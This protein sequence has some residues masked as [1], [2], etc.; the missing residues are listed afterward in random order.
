M[1]I[2]VVLNT[3]E[4]T[5]LG[6]PAS[7]DLQVDIG[8]E[9]KRGSYIYSG[10]LDPNTTST[11]FIN[12]PPQ[13][14][15]LYYRTENNTIY[16]YIA[17]PGGNQW[18]VIA[19]FNL[20]VT[21]TEELYD[22][23]LSFFQ[24]SSA[25]FISSGEVYDTFLK[26]V[27]AAE[28]Y[29]TKEELTDLSLDSLIASEIISTASA[30]AYSSAS[31]YTDSE[32][33][34]AVNSANSYTDEQISIVS[35]SVSAV[36]ASANAYTDSLV[37]QNWEEDESGN[38][39][40]VIDGAFDIGSPDYRVKD[41]YLSSSS[42]YIEDP[43]DPSKNIPI[44]IDENGNLKIG[45]Q[46]L[47]TESSASVFVSNAINDLVGTTPENLNTLEKLAGAINNDADFLASFYNKTESD[48][49]FLSKASAS[50]QYLS[51][52]GGV[53]SGDLVVSGSVTY[54][55]QG[56]SLIDDNQIILNSSA[57]GT[58][59]LDATIQVNRGSQPNSV[60]KWNESVDKWQFTNNGTQYYDFITEVPTAVNQK[61]TNFYDIARDYGAVPN[62][63]DSRVKIQN[64]LNAARD[65]GGGIVYIPNGLWNLSGGL[66]IYS[67]THLMLSPKAYMRKLFSGGSMLWNGDNGAN[68][69]GYDGQTN[70]TVTGGTWDA[71]GT[72][73]PT[74]PAN[75]F[76]FAH[77][78]NLIFRDITFLNVGG[79]HAIEINST[80]NGIVDNC[81]FLGYIDTGDRGFSEAV[82]IDGAFRATLFGE[83]G[84]Y[85]KTTCQ[86]IKITNCYFGASG[87]GGTTAWPTAIGSH[88]AD[89]Q[90]SAVLT[91]RWHSHIKVLN[92]TFEGLTEFAVRSDAVWREAT[93]ADN[94]FTN[95][96]GGVGL[97]FRTRNLNLSWH[98]SFNFSIE[99][100]IFQSGLD[101]G[102]DVIFIRNV[103]GV[104]ISNN[105]FRPS[106]GTSVSYGRHGIYTSSG[107]EILITDNRF[108]WVNRHG[109]FI[110]NGT[111]TMISN[112]LIK[113]V[114]SE[115]NN[116]YSYI[117]VDG[118]TNTSM[119]ANRGYK[120]GAGST[121]LYGLRITSSTGTRGFGNFFGAN[122]TTSVSGTIEASTA[123]G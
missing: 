39:L 84:S 10:F 96:S 13:L 95:C 103:D 82:Q 12:N 78:Q 115:T 88:S 33:I 55:N 69:S 36:S 20:F 105:H 72:A 113:N 23:I 31:S 101:L 4:I 102:R 90:D 26:I 104:I 45:D 83:F 110:E 41:L 89:T 15:D 91:E 76:S 111:D 44:T 3:D 34:S 98:G 2:N 66:R 51:L 63:T 11:P 75:I 87:F 35:A 71:R 1:A 85:D 16:Q 119:I 122:A 50:T 94:L 68:Y 54:A 47:S 9:G 19:E 53:I 100:N 42:L 81:R 59:V 32:I 73:F 70:I 46:F 56:Q 37:L 108:E 77:S 22:E 107:T 80:K 30:A 74:T 28:I 109:I 48:Q 49:E 67:T 64:A 52:E 43:T 40:P 112:N 38:I 65:A 25:S 62:E 99:N 114:S 61:Q 118:S 29:A 27:D 14:R 60:I 121:A 97:G 8:P 57:S 24:G 106:P 79:Y 6:P 120:G 116:T 18:Q 93:I 123:N 21:Q 58:P 86:D 7:I 5:V 17:V 92:N 117:L